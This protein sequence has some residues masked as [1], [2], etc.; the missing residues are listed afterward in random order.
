MP[1]QK[2]KLFPV[3][4]QIYSNFNTISIESGTKVE[5]QIFTLD[6]NGNQALA[7]QVDFDFEDPSGI[8]T[9]SPEGIGHWY[10]EGGVEG[11]WVLRYS[12][13]TAVSDLMVNVRRTC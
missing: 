8:I 12:S 1:L 4:R 10:I 6:V 13:G 3:A 7:N 5:I 2:S 9:T 11:S